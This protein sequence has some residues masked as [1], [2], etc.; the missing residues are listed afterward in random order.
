MV[1]RGPGS[2]TGLR[3][4][5]M[6][7]KT[8]AYA[9]G[10]SLV[11]VDTFECIVRQVPGEFPDVEVIADAQQQKVYVQRFGSRP[12]SLVIL[13]LDAWLQRDRPAGTVVTGPGLEVFADRLPASLPTLPR[14]LWLPQPEGLL[15]VGLER[16]RR[17]E[18]DDPFA[19]EPL[20]LRASAAEE[21]WR[22]LGRK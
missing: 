14:P 7:A 18:R 21:Q 17:G 12:E 9:T 3:V 1:S 22:E 11:A 4:S 20:Y 2:Y 10:C 19:V 15:Q 16:L 13:P 8:L 5:V 6:S